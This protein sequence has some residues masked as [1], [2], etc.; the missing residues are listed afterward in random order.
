MPI[1]KVWIYCLLFVFV[2]LFLFVRLRISPARIKLGVKFF[3]WFRG[4]LGRE[5]PILGNIAP[6]KPKIGRIGHPPESKVQSGKT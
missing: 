4:V 6:Q 3:R 2:R 5:S 1:G